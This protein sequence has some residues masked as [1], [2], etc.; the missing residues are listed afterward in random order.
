MAGEREGIT[1][2]LYVR[3]GIRMMLAVAG[4]VLLFLVL[5]SVGRIALDSYFSHSGY[6]RKENYRRL[7][8]LQSYIR[9]NGISIGETDRIGE[10]VK[11]QEL[12][13]VQIY[14]GEVLLYD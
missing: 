9:E 2:S 3:F 12:V 4:A 5:Q 8:N 7:K 6:A 10:W 1:H 13:S 14:K 11:K